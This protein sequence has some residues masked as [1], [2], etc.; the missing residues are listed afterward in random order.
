MLV[1]VKTKDGTEVLLNT[2]HVVKGESRRLGE[3][4]VTELTLTEGDPIDV[5]GDPRQALAVLEG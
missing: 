3:R 4:T 1:V 5:E 2:I